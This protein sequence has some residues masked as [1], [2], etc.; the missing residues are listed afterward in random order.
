MVHQVIEVE[1]AAGVLLR[2]L[3]F[4][5]TAP[6]FLDPYECPSGGDWSIHR[7]AALFVEG[8][9]DITIEGLTFDQVSADYDMMTA[10]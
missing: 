6:T 4:T 7:G 5:A 8:S 3:T 9:R 2:G 1:G 10:R